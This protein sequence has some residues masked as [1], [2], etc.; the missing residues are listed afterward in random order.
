[1][2]FE[3]Y[4]GVAY[5][6]LL[7]IFFFC[8]LLRCCN[9]W[10]PLGIDA[11]TL[12]PARRIVACIY[13]S[14]MLLL[15]CALHPQ[16]ADARLLAR[17]FWI[18]FVPAA[19]SLGYKRFFYGDRRHGLLRLLLVGVVPLVFILAL[20]G[21]ALAGGDMLVPHRKAVIHAAGVLGALLTAYQLHVMLWLWHV[22]SGADAV[23]RSADRLFPYNFASGMLLVSSA[24]QVLTW[25]DFLSDDISL[26]TLLAGI[27]AFAGAAILFTILH[28]QRVDEASVEKM[29]KIMLAI[30]NGYTV[31]VVMPDEGHPAGD[32]VAHVKV[33]E[34]EAPQESAQPKEKK[35]MLSEAQLDN[36]ERQIRKLVEGR[37]MYLNPGLK[38]EVLE[39]ML[40][41]NRTYLSEVFARRFGSFNLYLNTLRME[42]AIRY[43]A[44]HPD[45]K[46][47][48]VVRHSG[49]G[50]DKSYYRAKGTYEAEKSSMTIQS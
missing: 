16:S 28:P 8:G 33:A 9:F 25:V 14:V 5:A 11:D 4:F 27:V 3:P 24:I 12:Y 36:L 29:Q 23:A 50:S 19:T 1:M 38:Q 6:A 22:R 18:L 21:I 41:V 34:V 15:P 30:R 10:K 26:N 42:H 40:G 47:S 32:A 17:C 7:G 39:K 20:S 49:F 2:D 45:A 48:E 43:A 37:R 31:Q 35:Y 46:Q 44:E 13:F